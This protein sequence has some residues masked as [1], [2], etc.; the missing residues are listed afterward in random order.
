MPQTKTNKQIRLEERN[1]R[2]RKRFNFLTSTK[3]YSTDFS[4]QSL[5]DEFIPL[6]E[7]T[8]WLIVSKTG[9]YKNK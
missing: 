5:A 8:I 3:H 6:T 1:E 2:I 4:L 7:Q 9:Y